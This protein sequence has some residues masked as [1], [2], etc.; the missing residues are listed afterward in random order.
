MS[1]TAHSLPA[2][3]TRMPEEALLGQTPDISEYANHSFFEW[4][5]YRDLH[6]YPKPSICLGRWIGIASDVG[7][8]MTYCILME[9]CT[10]I[11]HSSVKSLQAFEKLDPVITSQQDAFM[12]SIFEQ[13]ALS[14]ALAD[15]WINTDGKELELEIDPD[16]ETEVYS[17][18]EA[19]VFTP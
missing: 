11:A 12:R 2:L 5:W 4:I 8:P 14:V 6:T 16:R 7:Q 3:R 13:K 9:K 10:I 17:T 18:P 1:L 15:P 19:D